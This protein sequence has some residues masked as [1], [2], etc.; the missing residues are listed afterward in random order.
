MTH[1]D[2]ERVAQVTRALAVG[3]A[4]PT[5]SLC[6]ACAEVIDVAG[7]GL[8]LMSRGEALGS[9]CVSDTRTEAV[10]D[11]QYALSEGP[12]VDAFHSRAPVSVPDLANLEPSRWG[13]FRAG[14]LDAGV[15]AAFGFPL[16]V[17]TICIGAL[18]LYHDEPG[19][20][21]AEQ[22]ANA[23]VVAHVATRT[24]LGWQAVAKANTLAW[25]L[26]QVPLHRA[27]VHQ[28]TGMVS[29]QARV[30]VDDALALIRAYAF[31]EGQPVGTIASEIVSGG[32][33]FGD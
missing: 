9:V 22:F 8:V 5:R 27:A 33:R 28:A 4:D 19:V 10:E 1:F 29:V 16:L 26:E 13:E 18:D 14:A 3:E 30:S 24:V 32:L 2:P 25:Q 7:A 12:C 17:E 11:I 20:L 23:Q 31:S 6:M 15:R 21:S